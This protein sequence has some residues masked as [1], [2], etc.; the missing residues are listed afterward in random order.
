LAGLIVTHF[1]G[2]F[3]S[4]FVARLIQARQIFRAAVA[5][6]M[7]MGHRHFFSAFDGF[8]ADVL[9]VA[10]VL[11]TGFALDVERRLWL[12][13]RFLANG[14]RDRLRFGSRTGGSQDGR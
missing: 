9:G 6:V 4:C 12:V 5:L 8:G 11:V 14:W 13:A 2:D 10:A 3:V 1:R 7:Q